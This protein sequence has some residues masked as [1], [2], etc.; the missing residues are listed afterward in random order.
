MNAV[1]DDSAD[2][3]VKRAFGRFSQVRDAIIFPMSP[4]PIRELGTESGFVFRLQDRASKGNEALVAAKNQLLQLARQSKVFKNVRFDG[5]ENAAQL[6]LKIDREKANALGVSFDDID[7]TLATAFGSNYVNDFDS[8]GRQQRVVVE[9]VTLVLERMTPD[10]IKNLY[11]RNSKGTMV[12]FLGF[13]LIG[14]VQWPCPA[15][16]L[17]R[18]SGHAYYR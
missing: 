2:A 15:D 6:E 7:S 8:E 12:P 3:I 11:V 16:P 9:L 17:Q 13:L 10:D 4:P 5:M 18:V 1:A 14:M